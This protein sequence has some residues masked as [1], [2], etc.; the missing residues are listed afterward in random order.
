MTPSV[1]ETHFTQPR[2]VT[3]VAPTKTLPTSAP[4]TA[5]PATSNTTAPPP[6]PT[7]FNPIIGVDNEQL[8]LILGI[9]CACVLFIF[10]LCFWR[11][12][13]RAPRPA[14]PPAVDE[15]GGAERGAMGDDEMTAPY[16]APA[17]RPRDG[18]GFDDMGQYTPR[19]QDSV[20]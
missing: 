16:V 15:A 3:F 1:T 13:R 2:T 8:G 18:E 19:D 12:S 9:I 17:D 6:G 4:T 10:F 11:C 14:Y 5:P 7:E 20:V